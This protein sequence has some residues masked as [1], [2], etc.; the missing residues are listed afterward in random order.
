MNF[1]ATKAV[2]VPFSDWLASQADAIGFVTGPAYHGQAETTHSWLL[3][4]V[5][6]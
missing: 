6:V 4:G 1:F 2:F 5:L 3:I